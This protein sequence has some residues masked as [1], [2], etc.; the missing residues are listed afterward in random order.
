[1]QAYNFP[2]LSNSKKWLKKKLEKQGLSQAEIDIKIQEIMEKKNQEM[3]MEIIEKKIE[4]KENKNKEIPYNI[5]ELV[6]RPKIA[7]M[8]KFNL[9]LDKSENDSSEDELEAFDIDE[10][11]QILDYYYKEKKRIKHDLNYRNNIISRNKNYSQIFVL[12]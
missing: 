11:S 1:M 8:P 12:W 6:D 10:Y 4:K 3:G 7:S 5:N 2:L 9:S